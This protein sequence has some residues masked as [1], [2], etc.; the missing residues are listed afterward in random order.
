M[1]VSVVVPT[2]N[3]EPWIGDQLRALADQTY[4]GE[5][6]VIIA[7]NGSSDGTC[8]IA[9]SWTDRLPGLRVLDAS[10]GSGPHYNRNLG[11]LAASGDV[12]LFTDQDDI[13]C[14]GWIAHLTS[15]LRDS[16]I[17]T[18]PIEHF[19]DGA[20]PSW[21]DV[22]GASEKPPPGP[23]EPLIGCNMGIVREL[24]LE[25]GGFDPAVPIGWEDVDLGLRATRREVS[26]AW[27]EHALVLRRR[28]RSA[29]GVWRK[30]FAYGR[31]WTMLERRYPEL[32]ADGGVRPLL[33][34]AV[35]VAIRSPYL[36]MPTRRR[37]WI[38]RAAGFAGRVTERLHPAT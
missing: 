28:P 8:S 18:G 14:P 1:T 13:V 27:A 35:W 10:D 9:A 24:L 36:A 2:F 23:F 11:A 16:P 38:V 12:V 33:R 3:G 5:W 20:R 37:G 29:R 7:D 25:L 31:G 22:R 4:A 30:E 19:V 26:I 21:G 34:R 15:S 6:E 17:A 32:S